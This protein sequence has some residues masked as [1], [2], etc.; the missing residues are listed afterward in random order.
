MFPTH[1]R[2]GALLPNTSGCV[3]NVPAL[4]YS[5]EP[6]LTGAMGDKTLS[7]LSQCQLSHVSADFSSVYV[8]S[9]AEPLSSQDSPQEL[10]ARENLRR[11]HNR[12]LSDGERS[13]I[14]GAACLRKQTRYD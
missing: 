1:G 4:R 6:T 7:L 11:G 10:Q 5:T 14:L 13:G 9:V 3:R 2:S 12:E 8:S